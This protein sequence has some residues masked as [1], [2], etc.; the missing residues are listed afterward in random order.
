MYK[1]QANRVFNFN[2]IFK[3]Y[4]HPKIMWTSTSKDHD[5]I[6]IFKRK[7]N[8]SVSKRKKDLTAERHKLVYNCND[9]NGSQFNSLI[10]FYFSLKTRSFRKRKRIFIY[11]IY[12]I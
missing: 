3:E 8:L 5:V 11:M 7:T 10:C 6:N 12:F 9:L 2:D 1:T 4:C